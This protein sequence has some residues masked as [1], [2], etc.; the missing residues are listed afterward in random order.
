MALFDDTTVAAFAT[1]A[2]TISA[3]VL[4]KPKKN[5]DAGV[6]LAKQ[7]AAEQREEYRVRI[8]DLEQEVSDLRAENSRLRDGR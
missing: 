3:A 6:N 8:R 4:L 2:A 5:R 7:L 1:C